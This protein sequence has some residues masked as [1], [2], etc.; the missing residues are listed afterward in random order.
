M[1]AEDERAL[2]ALRR[3]SVSQARASGEAVRRRVWALL[4]PAEQ[5]GSP[6]VILVE[7]S[8]ARVV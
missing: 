7:M 1:P 3:A 4:R 5:F 2:L 6:H 8:L